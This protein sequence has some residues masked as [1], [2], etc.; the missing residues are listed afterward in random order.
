MSTTRMSVGEELLVVEDFTSKIM[1]W[2]SE[3]SSRLP[4]HHYRTECVLYHN[5]WRGI[6]WD[7]R[8]IDMT[9]NQS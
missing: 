4:L 1:K 2:L 8:R 6:V 3:M 9:S 7:Y 5:M